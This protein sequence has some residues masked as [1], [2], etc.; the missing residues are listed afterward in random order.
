MKKDLVRFQAF[1]DYGDLVDEGKISERELFK[2]IKKCKKLHLWQY[3]NC[4]L[5]ARVATSDIIEC[6]AEFVL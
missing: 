2:Q 5:I 1:S 3:N 4:Y 6:G